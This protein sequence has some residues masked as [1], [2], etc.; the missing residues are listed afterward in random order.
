MKVVVISPYSFPVGLAPTNRIMAIAK[1]L[2]ANECE[3]DICIPFPTDNHRL[4]KGKDDEGIFQN[5]HFFFASGR[6]KSK[7]QFLRVLS[8]FTGYRKLNGYFQS[9]YKIY[10]RSRH[11]EIHTIILYADSPIAI[12]VFSF[13]AYFIRSKI[14]TIFDEFPTPIRH[15]LKNDIP[16]LKKAAYK[17][18]LSHLSGY[19]TI[20][21][22]LKEYFCNFQKKQTLIL[23][24]IIDTTR[25]N[26]I[27][28]INSNSIKSLCYM[29]NIELAKD[30]VDLIIEAFTLIHRKHPETELH[31]YGQPSNNDK[32][33]LLRLIKH[34][35]ISDRVHFKGII[36]ADEVPSVLMNSF[37]LVSSQ[38]NTLR[39]SGGFPTKL[40]EYLMSGIPV[41]MTAVG[42]NALHF[43]EGDNFYLAKPDSIE[44]YSEKLCQI[45]DN[46]Q[47]ATQIAEKGKHFV[48]ENFS[49]TIQGKKIKEFICTI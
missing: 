42:E 26:N 31:L 9:I 20:S 35:E 2:I 28:K 25:F 8:I 6:Y 11:S 34:N 44:D 39:A 40:G 7:F 4:H 12:L 43:T 24:L 19:I 48:I 38:P 30:N 46:Y 21:N 29:G 17:L 10:K 23:P 32:K 13:F 16:F 33:F 27:K 3:V 37:I 41:L 18:T 36:K 47:K 1:G 14:I 45:I 49:H 15:K 5:I 22:E